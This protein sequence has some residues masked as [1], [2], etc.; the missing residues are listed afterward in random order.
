[1]AF[2]PDIQTRRNVARL[3]LDS[4]C[5]R[6]RVAEPFRLPSGWAS[7]VYMDCRRLISFPVVRR[8]I[9]ALGLRLLEERGCFKGVD[10]VVGAEASGIAFAAWV[11]DDRSLP[12]HYVRKQTRGLGASSQ[13]VGVLPQSSRLLLVD[14]LVAAGTSKVNFIR[15]IATAGATVKDIFVIFDYGTFSV[16]KVLTP[17]G[18]TLHSLACWADVLTVGQEDG[19]FDAGAAAELAAFLDNPPAWSAAHGGISQLDQQ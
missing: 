2:Q 3:L 4:G 15:A 19:D 16:D 1:M 9:I 14:D 17:F 8:K 13:L 10:G 11:A 5:V 18:V 6:C 12:L 7:P